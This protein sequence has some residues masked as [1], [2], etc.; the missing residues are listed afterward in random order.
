ME[1]SVANVPQG[2][3]SFRDVSVDLSQEEWEC[4]DC[5]QRALYTDV[6]LENYSNL[7]FVENHRICGKHENV[8]HQGTN[9]CIHGHE[10]IQEKTNTCNEPGKVIHESCQ[11]SPYDISDTAENYNNYTFCNYRGASDETLNLNRHKIGN[12]EEEPSKYK[13]CGNFL[14]VGSIISKNQ[15]IHTGREVYKTTKYDSSFES[16]TEI[17]LKQTCCRKNL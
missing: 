16:N 2:L 8:L 7:L 17:T 4:L 12:A 10:Y 3:L 14:Y 6:M 5:V 1:A 15:R 13:D 11:Y 9:Y